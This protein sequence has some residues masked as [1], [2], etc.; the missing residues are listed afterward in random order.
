MYRPSNLGLA[1]DIQ[2]EFSS[3]H[4]FDMAMTLNFDVLAPAF[5]CLW[6]QTQNV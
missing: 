2:R 4:W 5:L 3:D 1:E 6:S